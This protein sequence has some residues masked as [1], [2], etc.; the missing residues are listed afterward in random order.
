MSRTRRRKILY[1]AAIAVLSV[2]VVG[3]LIWSRAPTWAWVVVAIALFVPGRIAGYYYRTFLI[4]RRMMNSRSYSEAIPQFERFLAEVRARPAL[5]KFIW[6]Q[7]GI[8]TLDV[9]AM[10]LNN[11]GACHLELGQLELVEEPLRQ[12]LFIDPLYPI[13]YVNL[14]VLAAQRRDPSTARDAASRAMQLGYLGS[15]TDAA[16]RYAGG[17]LAEFE[18]R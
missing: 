16:L 1:I 7:A 2:A 11:I 10:T 6:L 13:P 18:G 8:Y 17:A 3:G 14:A 5:K 4:G 12:A 15:R 9:E